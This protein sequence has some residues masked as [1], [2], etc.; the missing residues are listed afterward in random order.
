MELQCVL[1]VCKSVVTEPFLKLKLRSKTET[2][3]FDDPYVNLRLYIP[4]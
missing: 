4:P 3:F 1:L 2:P